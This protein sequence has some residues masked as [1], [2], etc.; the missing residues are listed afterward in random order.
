MSVRNDHYTLAQLRLALAMFPGPLYQSWTRVA[1][2]QHTRQWWPLARFSMRPTPAAKRRA[3]PRSGHPLPVERPLFGA[4]CAG[5]PAAGVQV[6]ARLCPIRGARRMVPRSMRGTPKGRQYTPNVA[7]A[8]RL[9]GGAPQGQ[10]QSARDGKAFDRGD[11]R[12][13]EHEPRRFHPSPLSRRWPR[14]P[15]AVCLRS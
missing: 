7:F 15:T 4:R 14:W 9:P 1:F 6:R 13:A 3:R 8:C 5:R 2:V 10:L 11:R 12:L